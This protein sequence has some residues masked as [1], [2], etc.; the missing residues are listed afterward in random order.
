MSD[1][2][3]PVI[4]ILAG[5]DNFIEQ[6]LIKNACN[7]DTIFIVSNFIN[8]KN[9]IAVGVSDNVIHSMNKNEV[10]LSD[11]I[12]ELIKNRSNAILLGDSIFDIRMA[13][14][15]ARDNALKIVFLEEK[16]E[17]NMPYYCDVF[18]VVCTD[19]TDYNEF[20]KKVWILRR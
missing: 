12:K 11:N 14:E 15:E 19:N 16:V 20:S 3:I 5:I 10:S 6:F 7:F 2:G 17:E 8:F 18:D 9:G 1:R 4:I 13:K